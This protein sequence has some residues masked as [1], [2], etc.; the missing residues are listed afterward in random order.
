MASERRERLGQIGEARDKAKQ[1]SD[2]QA[3]IDDLL[4]QLVGETH[5]LGEEWN[6]PAAG[7]IQ[8]VVASVMRQIR[9][10][11]EMLGGFARRLSDVADEADRHLDDEPEQ[12]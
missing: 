5:R 7:E 8:S 4:Q 11:S 3:T 1:L 9:D 10:A 2:A 12:D 6:D